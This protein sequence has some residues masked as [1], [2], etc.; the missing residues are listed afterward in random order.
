MVI[1]DVSVVNVAL[2]S[3]K[4]A[5]GFSEV[6]LQWVVNAYTVTFAGFLLLGGRLADLLGRR[7]V[8]VAGLVLFSVSSLVGG[9]SNNE[10]M[11]VVARLVQG[12]GGAVIGPASLALLTTTFIEPKE[13]HRAIGIWGAMGGA[14]GAAGV[15][16]GGILTDLLSWRWILFINVPIGLTAAFLAQR[17]LLEG[18]NEKAT[19]NFDLTGAITATAGLSLVVLGIVRTATHGWGSASTLITIGAGVALLIAFLV[20]EGNFAKAPLM[21]LRLFESR[22]LSSA[23]LVVVTLGGSTFAMWFFATLYLQDVE[24]YSPLL[25]GVAFLPM[26]VTLIISS[27][28]AAR[29]I[30]KIGVRRLLVASMTTLGIGLVLFTR[31]S[32]GGHFWAEML[33]ASV[34]AC[35]GMGFAFV[36]GMIAATSDVPP[37]QAGL[38]SGVANTSRLFGGALGLA[39]LATLAASRTKADL[40]HPTAAVHTM[41]QALVN[42]F[43]LSFWISAVLAFVGA[44]V[45]AIAMPKLK[46][47]RAPQPQAAAPVE[48]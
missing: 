14:G 21:P 30:A 47:T 11:L 9:F 20:I 22:A 2:P 46:P 7:S 24:G 34:V 23:N 39:V 12:V 44:A 45:A 15:L 26:T 42:G 43:R 3:I 10:T 37:H 18:R 16:L 40:S 41:N 38:A 13:R 32:D 5:L 25:T 28:L 17:L 1:L 31:I 19:R 29:V 35:I 8:F 48:V 27:T 4:H 6:G 33:P 36:P